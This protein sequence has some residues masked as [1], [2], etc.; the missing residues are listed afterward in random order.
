MGICCGVDMVEIQRIKDSID[1]S[2]EF[3]LRRVFTQG[4]INY[5]ESRKERRYESYAAR[6]AA[7]EAVSKALGTGIARGVS[8]KDIELVTSK[9]GKPKVVLHGTAREK[10]VDMSATSID[11]S[12]THSRD[13]AAA[14]A[15]LLTDGN[16]SEI[17]QD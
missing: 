2:G 1:K 16:K 8:L 15:V 12:L 14:F 3:F 13:Y 5:C 17:E 9:E 4:E 6:F 10:Y 11:I 7:K